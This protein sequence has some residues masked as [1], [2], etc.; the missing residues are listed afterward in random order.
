MPRSISGGELSIAQ[1]ERMLQTRRTALAERMRERARLQRKLDQIDQQIRSM[2][3][4]SIGGG[5]R[6][7]NQQSLMQSLETVLKD[8]GKPM[9]VADITSAVQR[10]G[11]RSNSANFR[12]IVNQ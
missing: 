12:G 8:S 3:G 6:V 10:R 4:N 7:K 2:G 5:Q 11:Y 9:R 1:L